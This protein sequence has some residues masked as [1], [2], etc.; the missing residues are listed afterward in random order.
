MT[1]NDL[2]GQ[3]HEN[4]GCDW[5]EIWNACASQIFAVLDEDGNNIAFA[6]LRHLAKNHWLYVDET[7]GYLILDDS[8]VAFLELKPL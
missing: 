4:R 1:A 8:E 6:Q 3:S 2:H 5:T 7:D